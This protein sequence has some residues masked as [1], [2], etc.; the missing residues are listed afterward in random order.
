ML[1]TP[2]YYKYQQGRA[3]NMPIFLHTGGFVILLAEK[4]VIYYKRGYLILLTNSHGQL[5]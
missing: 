1:T 2:Y 5:V 3:E 4:N